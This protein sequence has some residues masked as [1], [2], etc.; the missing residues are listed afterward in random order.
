MQEGK[1]AIQAVSVASKGAGKTLTPFERGRL[2]EKNVL[3]DFGWT[4]NTKKIGNSIPDAIV[5]GR[6]KE[7]KDVLYL[8]MSK[9]FREY[10]N[11]GK[12]IDLIVNSN[13]KI[14]KPLMD[15]IIKSGGTV[16]RIP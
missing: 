6:I 11:S 7:I 5:N 3:N 10:V 8:S 16:T 1:G 12:A 15:A 13:T 2:F 9:Q 4:K 14:S